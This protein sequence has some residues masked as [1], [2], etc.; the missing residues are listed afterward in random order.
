MTKE[1]IL[2]KD[3]RVP[4]RVMCRN[5]NLLINGPTGSG[6]T[7][8]LI[9]PNMM[10]DTESSYV[11]I[12][13]KGALLDEMGNM[14]DQ[15]GYKVMN[16]DLSGGS[17]TFYYNPLLHIKN[18]DDIESL[19][20]MMTK[21]SGSNSYADP[22]WDIMAGYL[23]KGLIAYVVTQRDDSEKTFST[24]NSLISETVLQDDDSNSKGPIA[25]LF[26]KIERR[27]DM[28]FYDPGN[29]YDLM[30]IKMLENYKA[31]RVKSEKTQSCIISSA[32]SLLNAFSTAAAYRLT[33]FGNEV[34]IPSIG[35]TKTALF[36]TVPDADTS[37]HPLAS[38]IIQQVIT[39]LFRDADS[40]T[41]R[42][43]PVPVRFILDDFFSLVPIKSFPE[44]L[45]TCRSRNISFTIVLQD[46]SQL[47]TRYKEAAP[48]IKS[49]CGITVFLGCNDFNTALETARRVNRPVEEILSFPLN[50][51]WVFVQGD[52]PRYVEK[53]D[54][55]AHFRYQT[56]HEQ[57]DDGKG[58]DIK[59]N[60]SKYRTHNENTK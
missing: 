59:R 3:C 53:Y 37:N 29:E 47:E 38:L 12:D 42:Q 13:P 35:H 45:S 26:E 33:S 16:L 21:E 48:S 5:D 49:N 9:K 41:N 34:D 28:G 56:I 44:I 11:I 30:C 19:V 10:E 39:E 52:L 15:S 50:K 51:Q 58:F 40:Q 25:L 46:E 2:G 7:R 20:A 32:Y 18:Q 8:Y 23:L 57:V 4:T 43:L 55:K 60:I 54:L 1:M 31:S 24:L 27:M 14:L 22:Y 6:K 17:D 36:I